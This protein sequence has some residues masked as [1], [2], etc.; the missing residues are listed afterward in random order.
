V[1]FW[2][3]GAVTPTDEIG[4]GPLRASP[5]P[6]TLALRSAL[7]QLDMTPS[8]PERVGHIVS[9]SLSSSHDRHPYS[10]SDRKGAE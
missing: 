8:G 10:R 1:P 6:T 4:R 3:S 7:D 9:T 2:C 5:D